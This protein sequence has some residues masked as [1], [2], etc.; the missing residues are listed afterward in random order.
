MDTALENG[1]FAAGANG[2]PRQ[3]DGVDELLQR[4]K[5]RLRV[6]LG[7]F[8][9]QPELGSRLYTLHAGDDGNDA[10]ALTM[11]QEALKRLPQLRVDKAVCSVEEPLTVSVA[12]AWSG[13][14]SVVEVRL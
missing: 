10:L 12:L 3:I 6:P 13:G 7:R 5:I 14:E 1:D 2:F 4:A 8:P 9:Y 11:A